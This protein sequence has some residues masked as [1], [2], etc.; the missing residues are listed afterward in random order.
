MEVNKKITFLRE[1]KGLTVNKL[2]NQAGISQSFLREIELGNKQPTIETLSLVC[3]ALN[4]SLKDFFDDSFQTN[5]QNDEL[6]QEIFRLT[7]EQIKLLT[8]FLKSLH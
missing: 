1:Q 6:L 2:A 5:L 3:G 7:P 8:T 4:V